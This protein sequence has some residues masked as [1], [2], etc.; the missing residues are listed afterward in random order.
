MLSEV[1]E[2]EVMRRGRPGDDGACKLLE[3]TDCADLCAGDV[4]IVD[5][6]EQARD[7][8]C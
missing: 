2:G 4:A 8:D 6:G 5:D 7:L 3:P 1:C